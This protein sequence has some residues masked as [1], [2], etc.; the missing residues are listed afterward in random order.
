MANVN[1]IHLPPE[2]FMSSIDRDQ[3]AI[4]AESGMR[5]DPV[6]VIRTGAFQLASGTN[7]FVGR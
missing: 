3:P 4:A 6:N 2:A 1:H 7:S 5:V